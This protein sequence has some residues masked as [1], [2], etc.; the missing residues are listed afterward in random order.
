MFCSIFSPW[1]TSSKLN[2][3]RLSPRIMM[4]SFRLAKS[5][6]PPAEIRASKTVIGTTKSCAPGD[7]TCLGQHAFQRLEIC[8]IVFRRGLRDLFRKHLGIVNG[9]PNFG[10]WPPQVPGNSRH[11]PLV[12]ADE[13][14]DLPN[15]ER[16]A[17]KRSEEHTS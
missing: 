2:F 9:R 17:L 14:H 6:N 10:F 5:K 16:T 8:C 7:L 11:I 1:S 3:R 4:M 13:Q 12:A 15:C